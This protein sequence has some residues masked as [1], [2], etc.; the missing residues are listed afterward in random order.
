MKNYEQ[1]QQRQK[2]RRRKEFMADVHNIPWW[3]KLF[4]WAS[5]TGIFVLLALAMGG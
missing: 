2:E 1:W 5:V 4:I 3:A